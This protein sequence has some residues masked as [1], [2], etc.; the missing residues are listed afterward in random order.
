MGVPRSESRMEEPCPAKN[1]VEILLLSPVEEADKSFCCRLKYR[2]KSVHLSAKTS[3][4]DSKL[5]ASHPSSSSKTHQKYK[6]RCQL[7]GV[8]YCR[9][10]NLASHMRIHTG[11]SPYCC[12]FC[13]KAFRRSDHLK[14]HVKIHTG[15]RRLRPKLFVCEQCGMK[16][17]CSKSLQD[18]M[19]KHS[20]ER[21][22]A[23]S[24]CE[25][26]FFNKG[27][28]VRHEND[29]HSLEKAFVCSLCGHG[30]ARLHTLE[31]HTRIHTGEK[32][33][34]CLQCGKMFR[35]KYSLLMHNKHHSG[36]G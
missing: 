16:F 25:K 20:G 26:R 27:V 23:C 5:S 35:Y 7:C 2:V 31:K 29:C 6:F 18:H 33:Y 34:T 3:N 15:E 14:M 9:K 4:P 12:T 28:L 8:E 24:V 1:S 11:E 32:P 13:G 19:W 17:G 22:F 36:K 10:A 21:P 30:F